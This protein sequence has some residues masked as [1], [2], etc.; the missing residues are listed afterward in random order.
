MHLF[1][2]LVNVDEAQETELL[3][4]AFNRMLGIFEYDIRMYY[5]ITIGIGTFYTNVNDIGISYN[6]AMTAL[7]KRNKEKG[8]RLSIPATCRSA[9]ATNIRCTT[10][11]SY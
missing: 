1:V 6:E 8:F 4:E 5:D 9:T 2:G 10:S 7:G 3:Y 11:R